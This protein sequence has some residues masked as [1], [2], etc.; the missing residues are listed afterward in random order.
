M[1]A[2][3]G[4]SRDAVVAGVMGCR[5]RHANFTWLLA[6]LVHVTCSCSEGTKIPPTSRQGLYGRVRSHLCVACACKHGFSLA[7]LVC[8][9]YRSE[10]ATYLDKVAREQLNSMSPSKVPCAEVADWSGHPAV[11]GA[12]LLEAAQRMCEIHLL[13]HR[14]PDPAAVMVCQRQASIP[15]VAPSSARSADGVPPPQVPPW[16]RHGRW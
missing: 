9:A 16:L 3:H 1:V 11:A 7:S 12:V 10:L 6:F 15:R 8:F 5:E 4:L 13:R 2:L 14:H